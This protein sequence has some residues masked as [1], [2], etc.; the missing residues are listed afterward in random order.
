MAKRTGR[1]GIPRTEAV[2]SEAGLFSELS[3]L[4]EQSRQQVAV[5][6]NS[7]LTVLFWQ[8]GRRI[9]EEV[10]GNQRADYG[11]QIVVTLSRQLE[12]EHG[13]NFTEKNVRRMMQFAEVFPDFE[14]VVP[15]ARQLSWRYC[16]F[17]LKSS[18]YNRFHVQGNDCHVAQSQIKIRKSS[19]ANL[20][21]FR[22]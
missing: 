15:L 4:I 22:P 20:P 13:R 8:I 2:L 3:H 11:K 18:I 19:I 9:N 7:A 5:Y 21:A 1:A 17:H 14:I 10:L 12:E 6:A 16:I